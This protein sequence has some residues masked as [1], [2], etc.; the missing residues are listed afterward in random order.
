MLIAE[1]EPEQLEGNLA[2]VYAY[3][4]KAKG[5]ALIGPSW[6]NFDML[7]LPPKLL[8]S[9]LVLDIA[10]PVKNSVYRYWGRELT[11]IHGADLTGKSPY[12]L[13]PQALADQL[14]ADHS[15][16]VA[17]RKPLCGHY[18]FETFDH[19]KLTHSMIRLPLS[20]DGET[21]S[22]ILIATD[23]SERAIKMIEK[24]R[25]EYQDGSRRRAL[26]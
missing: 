22:N 21:V 24:F 5:D 15:K 18:I 16:V 6:R 13:T 12:D 1:I 17:N 14:L 19:Y 7:E 8:P 11:Y 23:Y 4:L 9:L 10:E 3:W 25:M 20:S 2:E 26:A